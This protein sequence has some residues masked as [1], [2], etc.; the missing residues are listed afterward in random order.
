MGEL[1]IGEVGMGHVEASQDSTLYHGSIADIII[2]S[3]PKIPLTEGLHIGVTNHSDQNELPK[4]VLSR[5]LLGLGVSKTMA[6]SQ[7]LSQDFWANTRIEEGNNVSVYSR[8]PGS[9]DSWR[10][11]VNTVGRENTDVNNFPE[12]DKYEKLLGK[13]MPKWE[14]LAQSMEL[15]PDGV[16]GQDHDEES[17]EGPLLWDN[18]DFKVELI[19]KRHLSG[20]HIVVHPKEGFQR[21]W[22][23]VRESETDVENQK[24]IQTYL[25]RTLEATAVAHTIKNLLGDRG[26][27][28][29]SGNWAAGLKFVDEGGVLS[30]EGIESSPRLEKRAHVVRYD[31]ESPEPYVLENNER[32]FFPKISQ[33][34][35]QDSLAQAKKEGLS[36]EEQKK[37]EEAIATW[38]KINKIS[39]KTGMHVHIYIPKEGLDVVLP[40]MSKDEA[41]ARKQQAISR[42]EPV[43]TFDAVIKQW[44]ETGE[45]TEEDI[46]QVRNALRGKVTERLTNFYQGPLLQDSASTK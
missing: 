12:R 19:R 7:T 35:A 21:Q 32:I 8:R 30:R 37:F 33:K 29:N 34:D 40:E 1:G 27:I 22:Q 20:L 42:G 17:G 5:F 44:D 36:L 46:I 43:E 11:P 10:K 31:S 38:D 39:F 41:M 4:Q 6:E 24:M 14:K 9:A 18:P 3:P 2:P 23:T 45:A 13:Y 28:H 15:F 26:E 25:Q 16:N